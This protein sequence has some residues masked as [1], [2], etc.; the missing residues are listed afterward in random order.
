MINH[1]NKHSAGCTLLVTSLPEQHLELFLY[2]LCDEDTQVLNLLVKPSTAQELVGAQ[3]VPPHMSIAQAIN[4]LAH[5]ERG[6]WV[7]L[8]TLHH[9]HEGGDQIASLQVWVVLW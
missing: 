5:S 9:V 1:T 7:C 2:E 3:H 4:L 6:V 8:H